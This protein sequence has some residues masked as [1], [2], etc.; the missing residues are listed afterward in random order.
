MNYEIIS[1]VLAGTI[2]MIVLVLFIVF[3]I[4]SYQKKSL[5][6]QL[7]LEKVQLESEKRATLSSFRG[8]ENERQRIAKDLHDDVSTSLTAIK[9]GLS[10]LTEK[11]DDHNKL[12]D[13]LLNIRDD[14]ANSIENVRNISHNLMPY[15]LANLGLSKSVEQ[16]VNHLNNP[17]TYI[18]TFHS[19]GKL[20]KLDEEVR[21]MLFRSIKEVINNSLKHS[22]ASE[23]KV[24][25]SWEKGFVRI[26]IKDNGCGFDYNKTMEDMNTGIGLRNL[27][28][29]IRIVGATSSVKS[30]NLG[31]IY[32]ILLPL[33]ENT[34][35]Q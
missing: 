10:Y 34:V 3:F 25:F 23:L 2:G 1:F 20:V 31:T 24:G 14:L 17:P 28:S 19:S 8:Q 9:L 16:L 26:M 4:I 29:R 32:N 35:V 6:A 27:E 21:L 12:Q 15:A 30:D 13:E 18:A 33:N 11:L 7:K 5:Q 22:R